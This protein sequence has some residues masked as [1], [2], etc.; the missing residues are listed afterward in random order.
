MVTRLA[1]LLL[2]I[3][4]FL[5]LFDV[6]IHTAAFAKASPLLGQIVNGDFYPGA[7]R[8]VWLI[9]SSSLA[10]LAALL[11]AIAWRPGLATRGIVILLGL[12]PAAAAL[13]FY[14]ICGLGFLPGH[15]MAGAA[16]LT[17]AAGIQFP[18]ARI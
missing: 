5:L 12:M 10:V 15:L 13:L 14:S 18:P 11:I 16:I 6:A 9:D 3:A 8:A 2:G 1:R 17:I 4:A 7:L